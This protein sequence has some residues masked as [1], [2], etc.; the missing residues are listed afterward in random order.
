MSPNAVSEKESNVIDDENFFSTPDTPKNMLSLSQKNESLKYKNEVVKENSNFTTD[1]P[2]LASKNI[3][4]IKESGFTTFKVENIEREHLMKNIEEGNVGEKTF[5]EN[6]IEFIVTDL[7]DCETSKDRLKKCNEYDESLADYHIECQI[8]NGFRELNSED[9]KYEDPLIDKVAEIGNLKKVGEIELGKSIIEKSSNPKRHTNDIMVYD[10]PLNTKIKTFNEN[11][12]SL[13]TNSG[14]EI[15]KHTQKKDGDYEFNSKGFNKRLGCNNFENFDCREVCLNNSTIL[16][17]EESESSQTCNFN[18]GK[19]CVNSKPIYLN[20]C[21]DSFQQKEHI[22]SDPQDKKVDEKCSFDENLQKVADDPH[23][24]EKVYLQSTTI[25]N[26]LS[27]VSPADGNKNLNEGI[28]NTSTFDYII[29]EPNFNS[30]GNNTFSNTDK[31][32]NDS[33]KESQEKILPDTS[34]SDNGTSFEFKEYKEPESDWNHIKKEM[35]RNNLRVDLNVASAVSETCFDSGSKSNKS[36]VIYHSPINCVPGSNSV[37]SSEVFENAVSCVS[38]TTEVSNNCTKKFESPSKFLINNETSNRS[39]GHKREYLSKSEEKDPKRKIIGGKEDSKINLLEDVFYEGLPKP[40]FEQESMKSFDSKNFSKEVYLNIKKDLT[41]KEEENIWKK[42]SSNIFKKISE[43]K[44]EK[45]NEVDHKII[46][47]C[48]GLSESKSENQSKIFKEF[49]CSKFNKTI[50]RHSFVSIRCS[51]EIL[52][53][54]NTAKDNCDSTLKC[55]FTKKS[56][57]LS[58][59]CPFLKFSGSNLPAEDQY[60]NI[61]L[62]QIPLPLGDPLPEN[63][64]NIAEYVKKN[65]IERKKRKTYNEP[66]LFNE[67]SKGIDKS[68]TFPE[69]KA[70][71]SDFITVKEETKEEVINEKNW[72]VQNKSNREFESCVNILKNCQSPFMLSDF[73]TCRNP[74]PPLVKENE[75][76]VR[77]SNVNEILKSTESPGFKSNA[78]EIKVNNSFDQDSGSKKAGIEEKVQCQDGSTLKSITSRSINFNGSQMCVINSSACDIFHSKHY[79]ENL[80]HNNHNDKFKNHEEQLSKNTFI[81]FGES[82]VISKTE[83]KT[84]INQ[85]YP[86]LRC[87]SDSLKSE[88]VEEGKNCEKKSDLSLDMENSRPHETVGSTEFYQCEDIPTSEDL[89]SNEDDI[90]EEKASDED[91]FQNM[92]QNCLENAKKFLNDGSLNMFSSS[93]ED[94]LNDCTSTKSVDDNHC[95]KKSEFNSTNHISR[96]VLLASFDEAANDNLDL[97]KHFQTTKICADFISSL[98]SENLTNLCTEI[99]PVDNWPYLEEEVPSSPSK[100]IA[101]EPDLILN[102]ENSSNLVNLEVCK[103]LDQTLNEST[104]NLASFNPNTTVD[105]PNK[106]FYIFNCENDKLKSIKRVSQVFGERN[107]LESCKR[108]RRSSFASESKKFQLGSISRSQRRKTVDSLVENHLCYHNVLEK[109]VHDFR[110][111]IVR[112]KNGLEKIENLWQGNKNLKCEVN[113]NSLKTLNLQKNHCKERRNSCSQNEKSIKKENFSYEEVQDLKNLEKQLKPA[114]LALNNNLGLSKTL[115]NEIKNYSYYNSSKWQP[116]VMLFRISKKELKLISKHQLKSKLESNAERKHITS[117]KNSFEK[118]ASKED[119]SFSK[120]KLDSLFDAKDRS[121]EE[122]TSET[123]LWSKCMTNNLEV[124]SFENFQKVYNVIGED[125][126]PHS[127]ESKLNKNQMTVEEKS[128]NNTSSNM[129]FNVSDKHKNSFFSSGSNVVKRKKS[130]FRNLHSKKKSYTNQL[131]KED[132][133]S[134]EKNLPKKP[135]LVE[136]ENILRKIFNDSDPSEEQGSKY[137]NKSTKIILNSINVKKIDDEIK[138]NLFNC[139]NLYSP[140]T[141]QAKKAGNLS[142]NHLIKR[143]LQNYKTGFQNKNS[144]ILEEETKTDPAKSSVFSC[145]SNESNSNVWKNESHLSTINKYEKKSGTENYVV[146]RCENSEEHRKNEPSARKD[147]HRE[148]THKENKNKKHGTPI[149]TCENKRGLEQK[150][151]YEKQGKRKCEMTLSEET[152][153][154]KKLSHQTDSWSCEVCGFKDASERV[155]HIKNHPF[156]CQSCHLAFKTEVR[157]VNNKF[158]YNFFF[159]LI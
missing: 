59:S 22:Q 123:R 4:E 102:L 108:F 159:F 39:S 50:R 101:D 99:L 57:P 115:S 81:S 52:E 127:S 44:L 51:K 18:S 113:L 152:S 86:I 43:E 24:S 53:Y 131:A 126:R 10:S 157:R 29:K 124:D 91:E 32:L 134:A 154:S 5:C 112:L 69:T 93:V 40:H 74:S 7:I 114:R 85:S 96:D 117:R 28:L 48:L 119:S 132:S 15:K 65:N 12:G 9:L 14:H 155:G 42:S 78:F 135:I 129:T 63:C 20:S 46:P 95:S 55:G 118:K 111:E 143:N 1:I 16:T 100:S 139:R 61:P 145:N 49:K 88:A 64:F 79:S 47:T 56:F 121:S 107:N 89:P 82:G 36:S 76:V 144:M 128:L 103:E 87:N 120:R 133:F 90:E 151:P 150:F 35:D 54:E 75:K 77:N 73:K 13:P 45:S 41:Q 148:K 70:S 8:S 122:K 147:K 11:F 31:I 71:F 72:L 105:K 130:R 33:K 138:H 146:R 23:Q 68:S 149:K 83:T 104:R 34:F 94:L 60:L 140:E 136:T 125:M 26:S 156:H 3:H 21:N 158:L 116:K 110:A 25:S 38:K 97:S 92:M 141:N 19:N 66:N 106:S 58:K 84:N 17:N 27:E 37:F 109:E 30:K 142:E 2:N 80:T 6:E 62:E 98:G 153:M 137:K 67:V